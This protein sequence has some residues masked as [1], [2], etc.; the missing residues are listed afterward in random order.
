MFDKDTVGGI[1]GILAALAGAWKLAAQARADAAKAAKAAADAAQPKPPP[2]IPE[3]KPGDNPATTVN[4]LIRI[5]LTEHADREAERIA[6]TEQQKE[7]RTKFHQLYSALA[8]EQNRDRAEIK[9]LR[10]DLGQARKA[11][12]GERLQRQRLG[13][14]LAHERKEREFLDARFTQVQGELTIAL[15][16]NGLLKRDNERLTGDNAELR[17]V[18]ADL[19]ASLAEQ[20]QTIAAQAGQIDQLMEANAHLVSELETAKD[21]LERTTDLLRQQVDA[22][23][24]GGIN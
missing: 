13:N 23:Q 22:G 3:M 18:N 11:L 16:D 12:D 9:A 14:D 19:I 6:F 10:G 7:D 15:S 1:V 24:T 20:R 2:V 4:H 5:I 8:N 21:E 17:K